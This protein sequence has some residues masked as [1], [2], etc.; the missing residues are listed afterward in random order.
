MHPETLQNKRHMKCRPFITWVTLK[1][2]VATI[3]HFKHLQNLR[4]V[5]TFHISTPFLWNRNVLPALPT[6][7]GDFLILETYPPTIWSFGPWSLRRWCGSGRSSTNL[8]RSGRRQ[9]FDLASKQVD[10][11]VLWLLRIIFVEQYGWYMNDSKAH[12]K[13][14]YLLE[15]QQSIHRSTNTLRYTPYKHPAA[16]CVTQ[17][18]L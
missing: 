13:K 6:I 17:T 4:S 16:P 3:I 11:D 12:A 7:L 2:Q 18:K 9:C 8:R 15:S 10:K 1:L 14:E 5:L